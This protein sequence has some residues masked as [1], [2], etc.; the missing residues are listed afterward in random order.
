MLSESKNIK[1]DNKNRQAYY[2]ALENVQTNG[3]KNDFIKFVAQVELDSI[4]RYLSILK[5]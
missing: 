1:G 4:S 3:N 2:H 5:G